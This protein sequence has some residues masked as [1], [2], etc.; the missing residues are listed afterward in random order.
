[1]SQQD[2]PLNADGVRG[3]LRLVLDTNAVLDWLLFRDKGFLAISAAIESRGAVALTSDACLE[4]LRRVLRYPEFKLDESRQA[5]LLEQ[6][7]RHVCVVEVTE[8]A[9]P[10]EGN[11][12][13]AAIPRCKDPDDQKFL[14]LASQ[15]GAILVTKDKL[16]LQLARRVAKG[17]RFLILRPDLLVQ[18][19]FIPASQ[20]QASL[21]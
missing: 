12:S 20:T 19:Y 17:G 14:E 5:E 10:S 7:H 11:D 16:L 4:E 6:Y 9:L 21:R 15:Q 2:G 18:R 8:P 1:M 3:M 13:M